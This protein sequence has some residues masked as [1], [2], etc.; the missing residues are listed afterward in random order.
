MTQ[1]YVVT[2]YRFDETFKKELYLALANQQPVELA[3]EEAISF[4]TQKVT[5]QLTPH[6]VS[7]AGHIFTC[8]GSSE[9]GVCRL[10][11]IKGTLHLAV[12]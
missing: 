2:N 8:I 12:F 9:Q 3:C 7:N 10:E 11:E 4:T 6:Q 5:I 1:N